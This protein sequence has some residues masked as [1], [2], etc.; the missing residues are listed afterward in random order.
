MISLLN[1]GFLPWLLAAVIPIVV[2]L[3]T[4]RARKK[5]D[6]PTIKFLQKTVAQ[7][8]KIWKW[9][10]LV[11]MVLRGMAVAALVLAFTRPNWHSAF[12]ARRNGS[13]GIVAILDVSESMAYS[14]GGV[15]TLS[16][17]KGQAVAALSG[18]Q[19]GDKANVI[20]C[21]ALPVLAVDQP[22][23]DIQA[24]KSAV[25][26]AEPTAEKADTNAAVSAAVEQ[27]AK[28]N[29]KEKRLYI[30]SD[31][32]RT[33]WSEV[34][35]DA[36]P[37]DTKVI[38]VSVD[39]RDRDNVGIA[40][41]RVRPSTPRAGEAVTVQAEV[42]NSSRQAKRVP[43]ELALSTGGRFTETAELAP[44]SSANVSFMTRFD[45]PVRVELTASLKGDNLEV[46][47]SRRVV[48]DLQQMATVVLITDE[49]PVAP[50]SACYYLSRALHPDDQSNSGFRV[51]V[52][53]PSEL[54][55][56][57]LKSADVVMVAN[58][59]SMPAVQYEALAKYMIAGG[60]VAWF[61]YGTNIGEQLTKLGAKLPKAEPMP[62]RVESV[63]NLEGQAKGFVS[64]SEAHYESRLLKAF[65]DS[66]E[67]GLNKARF[68]K[69]CILSEVEARAEVL[70]KFEDGTPAALRSSEGIGNLL[71]LNMSP[72]PSWS[73]LARQEV[74]LPLLHE[75]LK[76]I[77]LH[78]T[79]VRETF[80][81]T[82]ASATIPP[83][84][85]NLTCISP[86]GTTLPV[87]SDKATG[88]L[89]V[90]Q[91][92]ESGFYR[93]F[94]G[95]QSVASI[96]VNPHPDESDLRSI[97]PRELESERN[98]QASHLEGA[99]QEA[100]IVELDKGRPL[101]PTLLII[102]LLCLFAEQLV[103]WVRPKTRKP[104]AGGKK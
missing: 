100:N 40:S 93:V 58:A 95:S 53:K 11:T 12:A 97:D 15:S 51:V 98:R 27:L 37:A 102:A 61:L 72:A 59:A 34:K 48:I 50:T 92:R 80:P 75:F 78:D 4:R 101:W 38:F 26:A 62:T 18:L 64:L 67:A 16:K 33:N 71:L 43:V 23:S 6:L 14:T 104:E 85:S 52:V 87:T 54:N 22:S 86:G 20:L 88:S 31:F 35:F 21:G 84:L 70:L 81:G 79:G 89:V 45:Q 44:F 19:S 83:S 30:F 49:S 74:F 13:A 42:F 94:S 36:V 29:T 46:D 25:Q 60:N 55:N 66:S 5:M 103:N 56:P 65:R 57:L 63:V 82:T 17:A 69:F 99:T 24:L 3:L 39:S 1:A 10:H 77:L 68:T 9:R 96:A 41:L 76:G 47:N 90:D 2:H 8:S 28:A 32:Q 7:Q 73:D 91:T